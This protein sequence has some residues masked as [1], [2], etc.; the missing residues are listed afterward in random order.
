MR[1]PYKEIAF[2]ALVKWNGKSEEEAM[3]INSYLVKH[4]KDII[5]F[6][7]V[8]FNP[9]RDIER[10]TEQI[11]LNIVTQIIVAA[12]KKQKWEQRTYY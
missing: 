11:A 4:I 1:V 9:L 12:E 6:D 7:M 5:S 2:Y 3:E 10:R 8:E